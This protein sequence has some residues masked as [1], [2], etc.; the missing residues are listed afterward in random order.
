MKQALFTLAAA[1]TL[2]ASFPA[3]AAPDFQAI[4]GARE[5]GH[6]E[7]ITRKDCKSRRLVL[8]LAHGP[9]ATSTPYLNEQRKKQFEAE[10][11]GCE[12]AAAK[13]Q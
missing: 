13:Q 7:A 10:L 1:V 11:K 6:R 9:R 2:S 12:E 8:P 3:T 5:A 4:E